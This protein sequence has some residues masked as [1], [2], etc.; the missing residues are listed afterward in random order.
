MINKDVFKPYKAPKT[1]VSVSTI[2]TPTIEGMAIEIPSYNESANGQ[3]S[4]F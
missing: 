1:K 4:F 3:L 2:K